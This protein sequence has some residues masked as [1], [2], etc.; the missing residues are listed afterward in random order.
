MAVVS[1]SETPFLDSIYVPK[2]HRPC[3]G[4]CDL[5]RAV[6]GHRIDS[7]VCCQCGVVVNGIKAS[8]EDKTC[9]EWIESRKRRD[10]NT[11]LTFVDDLPA[12]IAARNLKN[13]GEAMFWAA[14]YTMYWSEDVADQF[15]S[16]AVLKGISYSASTPVPDPMSWAAG[17][18][19]KSDI[20]RLSKFLREAP[21]R[22]YTPKRAPI[23]TE[24][25][26]VWV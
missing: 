7:M 1:V 21:E 13:L 18:L 8:I 17:H 22:D 9:Q 2:T 23:F 14:I 19:T 11:E 10:G 20:E 4:R 25:R 16:L 12:A 5:V 24:T 15:K 3:E 26:R 6:S